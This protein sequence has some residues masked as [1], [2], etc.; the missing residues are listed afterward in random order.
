MQWLSLGIENV[1]KLRVDHKTIENALLGQNHSALS[2][3]QNLW[4]GL[5]S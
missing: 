1:K 3:L 4:Y 5:C 2:D